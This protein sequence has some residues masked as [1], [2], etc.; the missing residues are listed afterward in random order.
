MGSKT[1]FGNG[2]KKKDKY[3]RSSLNLWT[4][5][6]AVVDPYLL[7]QYQHTLEYII[8]SLYIKREVPNSFVAEI[9]VKHHMKMS[10]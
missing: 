5:Y 2:F 9:W 1:L 6:H 4:F 7:N 10:E 8:Q 3:S